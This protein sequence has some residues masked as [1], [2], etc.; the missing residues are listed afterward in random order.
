MDREMTLQYR[1]FM[2]DQVERWMEQIVIDK[3]IEVPVSVL[4]FYFKLKAD[5][6]A[7]R[8]VTYLR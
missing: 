8:F 2:M 4:R 1:Q 3:D 5:Q 6:E 7:E